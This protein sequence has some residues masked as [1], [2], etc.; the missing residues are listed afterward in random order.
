MAWEQLEQLI[1]QEDHSAL[2]ELLHSLS[3]A[4]LARAFSRLGEDDRAK[5]LTLL[6]AEH[7]A[8]IIAQL[9]DAQSAD[10]LEELPAEVAADI[11]EELDS[12]QRADLL[13]EIDATDAEAI[14]QHMEP[15]EAADAR[16]LLNYPADT[17]GGLMVTEF[18]AFP[19]AWKVS[20]VVRNLHDH[21][22][23]YADYSIQYAYTVSDHGRLVGVLRLRDLLLSEDEV[24]LSSLMIANPIYVLHTAT[25]DELEQTFA[26]YPFVGLPVVEPDG[27]IIGVVRRLD[28]EEALGDRQ[29]QAFMRFGGI[30]TGEELRSMPLFERS[31]RRL[32]W[33]VINLALSL[34]AVTVIDQFHATLEA[35]IA[36]A[37]F[38]PV[39]ANLSGC[40]GNQAVTVSIRELS[41]GLITT[42][43]YVRVIAKESQVGLINGLCLGTLLA[44]VS[45]LWKHNLALSLVV[46]VAL[47][48]NSVIALALGGSI[49]LIV[50]KIKMD[51][52]LASPPLL[53]TIT[54]MCAFFLVLSIAAAVL[55]HLV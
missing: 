37:V 5:L 43:D 23:E 4:E 14:L 38:I 27:R 47:A 30:I 20:D 46:G 19:M 12:D 32:L 18:L 16:M 3:A 11:L 45:Y 7:A 55:T 48:A 54:D 33:L 8:D 49:P 41:L 53:T 34:L 28:T 42:E 52:A 13:G 39:V 29:E 44:G 35:V 6:E 21:A 25:L 51:P 2:V 24:P 36:L 50:R 1:E 17:A 9:S 10:L 26:R 15:E 31:F 40:A 22:R